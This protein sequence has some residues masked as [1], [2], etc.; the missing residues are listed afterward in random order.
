MKKYLSILVVLFCFSWSAGFAQCGVTI[1]TNTGISCFGM[2]DGA[3][4][5]NATGVAPFSYD[6]GFGAITDSIVTDLCAF[7]YSVTI[8]D[9]V[10]CTATSSFELT[11]PA[12]LNVTATKTEV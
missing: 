5:A 11:D 8:T 10:G 4:E 3:I 2:C 1:K 12:P 7:T 6:W 9:N